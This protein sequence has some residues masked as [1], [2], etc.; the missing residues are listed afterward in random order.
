YETEPPSY[1]AWD[2]QMN[3]K[4]KSFNYS[5]FCEYPNDVLELLKLEEFIH[6]IILDKNEYKELP[7]A[8][9]FYE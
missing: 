2:I 7:E 3:G 5:T 4:T 6:N 8:N 1:S 9:G